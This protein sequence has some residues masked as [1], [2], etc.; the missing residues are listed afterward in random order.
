MTPKCA[1]AVRAAAGR[2]ISDAK[3]RAIDQRLIEYMRELARR[4]RELPPAQR[5]WAGLSHEQR[6]LAAATEAMT[7]LQAE[8]TRKVRNTALQA[9]R[10]A[11]TE[12]RVA[13]QM[14]LEPGLTRSQALARDAQLTANTQQAVR[15]S[16]LAQ[17]GDLIDAVMSKDGAGVMRSL[18]MQ[19]F[20]L[21]NPGMTADVVREVFRNA[22]GSTGNTGARKAAEAWLKVTD[23]LRLRFNA[24]G[25]DVGKLSYGYLTQAH[26]RI[27]V[28]EAGAD[29]WA[30]KVLPMLDRERYVE[31]DGTLMSDAAVLDLLRAA[32]TTISENGA[33]KTEPGAFRG[34]GARANRGSEHRVLHF[35][36]GDAWIGYMREF[37]EG[38]LYDSMLGH[39]GTLSRDI[40]LVERYGP[41]AAQTWRVQADLAQRADGEGTLANRAA[42]NTPATYWKLISGEA[43]APENRTIAMWG[44]AMRGV[45][46]AAKITAG[47]LAALGD[48]A[49]IAS[50]LHFDRLPWFDMVKNIGRQFSSDQREFLRQHGV[51]AESLTNDINRMVGDHFT[52]NLVGHLPAAVM[53][54]SLLNA[55]TDGL[56]SAF[57]ATLM[58]GMA[59]KHGTAWAELD[60]WD[61]YLMQ[62][63]GITGADWEIMSR[64]QLVD[65]GGVPYLTPD[66]IRA[67]G[68]PGAREASTK[69]LAFVNDEAQFAVVNPDL[70]TRAITTG[71]AV[72]AGTFSGEAWRAA[73]QF[74]S[75]PIAMITRHWRRVLETPQGLEG[76]PAG[77]G[78][79]T[80]AGAV[81]NKVA[82]L[83]AFAVTAT[84]LGALQTQARH[85]AA[86]KDPVD[87]GG[88]H[89][90]KFWLKAFAAGGGSGFFGDVLTAPLDD[91]S[92]SFEGKLGLFGPVVGAAGGLI[93]VARAEKNQG[94]R[95]V[96]WVNDQLPGVDVWYLRALWEHEVLHNAQEALNPGY[97]AR[98]EARAQKDW[99]QSY[100]WSPDDAM[101]ERAPDLAAAVGQ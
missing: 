6:V 77:Y 86:G 93:D 71:G 24:A 1:T 17:L 52:H 53:R 70:A 15:D 68:A 74:K 28:L 5:T 58:Q 56:R 39:L 60:E 9:L 21:D 98:M 10:A 63:K 11:E 32:H 26:D 19:L 41:N 45:Q 83:A 29:G 23:D 67:T 72:Q 22:D 31:P 8:A 49:T 30:A 25:A 96:K 97:L 66:A 2:P 59:R 87:M 47:P 38:T 69:W 92:R 95:A 46:T 84:M 36:D 13:E 79:D 43:G 94:A 34:T 42:F 12:G 37:G 65:R 82:V 20:G 75:F 55:W 88:E 50:T 7:D 81:A 64:A 35:A 54:L 40:G 73:F 27:R 80:G 3:L 76:A 16:S 48:M 4:D 89:A 91:P 57:A 61:R 51:I 85:V 62:R 100:W 99:G 78:A 14:A 18:G 44:Q 90:G 101:P 33:N